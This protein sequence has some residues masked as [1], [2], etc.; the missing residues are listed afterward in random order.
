MKENNINGQ[1]LD[2]EHMKQKK[3]KRRCRIAVG[4]TLLFIIL[5][6]IIALILALT[7]FKPKQPR[8]QILSSALDG[9]AP[10][11]SF[12][13]LKIELNITL[14]L[15]LLVEN[16][17]HASFKHGAGMSYLLY[18]GKQVGEVQLS[19][20]NIPAMGSST[21]PCRLTLQ[22]DEF[23][24]DLSSLISDVLTGEL[25]INTHTRIPGK[26]TFLGFIKKHA[27]ALSDCQFTMDV[28][29]MKI[30]TQVCKNK[31]KL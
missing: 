7:V 26:V 13:A 23:A 17:N 6:F 18:R 21:L 31:T 22:A 4:V 15:K 20:G 30:K 16:K 5:I 2:I 25:V 8:T 28:I 27:V 9:V 1:A 14:D 3:T 24:S 12:P 10:R 29:Q 11:V 19:P